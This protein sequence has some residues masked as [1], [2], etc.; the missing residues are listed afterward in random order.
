[1]IHKMEEEKFKIDELKG[2]NTVVSITG[3]LSDDV[4]SNGNSQGVRLGKNGADPFFSGRKHFPE[5][6]G[7]RGL[8]ILMVMA[9][10]Y[11]GL[12][13]LGNSIP[14]RAADAIAARGWMGVDLFFVLSGFLITGILV[15]S[16]GQESYFKNF[17]A[18]RFLRIF[19]IYYG[20]L[21][22]LFAGLCLIK[23]GDGHLWASEKT[24]HG[25]WHAQ[26]FLWTYTT[27][28]AFV[29]GHATLP[30]LAHLWSLSVEEQFYIVWPLAIFL[31]PRRW[32]LHACL[33]LIIIGVFS[34]IGALAAGLNGSQI[35]FLTPCR[36]D[37]F[38]IGA[39]VAVV[40]RL[41]DWGMGRLAKPSLWIL[42][43]AA[44][45][46]VLS[47]AVP[48][49]APRVLA[50][51]GTVLVFLSLAVAFAALLI[52]AS[53]PIR[54]FR[55]VGSFFR[56]QPL[57]STGKYSYAMYILHVPV[58]GVWSLL[59]FHTEFGRRFAGTLPFGV[60]MLCACVATTY[61]F[62]YA[63]YHLYEK[64]FLKLKKYFPEKV[65]TVVALGTKP[66]KRI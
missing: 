52:I 24:L 28:L 63:S 48:A 37:E 27:N 32:L 22:V 43:P 15:D 7:L 6:D 21:T 66:A 58:M 65:G 11:S 3:A 39:L 38:G 4:V 35:Y 29:F 53:V 17:Y 41:P 64:H 44:I 2:S 62:A 51:A 8:A 47:A 49:T 9:F 30:Y 57:R 45:I 46:G 25:P 12:V 26:I 50:H 34:R 19:P 13:E 20:L 23:F 18:R 31:V 1:M 55:W 54:G 59:Q 16:K 33:A 61:I 36:M 60:G 5:L 42:L 10:H 56:L 40:A 14:A